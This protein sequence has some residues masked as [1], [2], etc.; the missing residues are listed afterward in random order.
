MRQHPTRSRL[1]NTVPPVNTR[2]VTTFLSTVLGVL[3]V[4]SSIASGQACRGDCNQ[5]CEVAVDDLVRLV[6]IALGNDVIDTCRAGDADG[7]GEIAIDDIVAAVTDALN[8]CEC[9]PDSVCGDG[10]REGNEECDNG[11]LCVGGPSAGTPCTE[12]GDCEGSGVCEG[13]TRPGTLCQISAECPEGRCVRCKAFGGDGCAANCTTESD[14]PVTLV[15]G[16]ADPALLPGTSGLSFAGATSAQPVP[17]SGSLMLTVGKERDGRLPF[18]VQASSVQFP[19]VGLSPG[20][21]ACVRGVPLQTC[22][23]SVFES[24]G[25]QSPSCTP[26]FSGSVTCPASRACTFVHGPGNSGSGF[27]ACQGSIS[28]D[29]TITQDAG[30]S[31]GTPAAPIL[32]LDGVGAAGSILAANSLAVGTSV[33]A[34]TP[35]FCS[36]ATPPERRGTPF[37]QLLTNGQA[38]CAIV[39]A[40]RTDDLVV[41]PECSEGTPLSCGSLTGATPS[42]SGLGLVGVTPVLNQPTI[43]DLCITTQLI[44]E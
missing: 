13:G 17:L 12:E 32:V 44:A 15:A 16:V 29:V 20:A 3:L 41:G 11:A 18:V 10:Q 4:W 43:G 14:V 31:S 19:S 40:N 36:D 30:G 35:A 25:R 33:G 42:T 37:T 28:V 5:D 24:D 22:G 2:R 6:V 39:N 27:V 34:C 26:T 21:C 1:T 8:G 7:N 23:G 38:C 9:V